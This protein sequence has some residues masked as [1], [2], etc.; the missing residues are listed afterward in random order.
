MVSS[1]CIVT[2]PS[3]FKAEAKAICALMEVCS[4][5]VHIRK[6]ESSLAEVIELLSDIAK[7]GGNIERITLH[8]NREVATQ[9]GLGGLHCRFSEIGTAKGFAGKFSV[10]CHSFLEAREALCAGASY[11]FLSPIF[12]S[13]S[14]RGY[15]A[16]FLESELQN[17]LKEPHNTRVVALGG[18][19]A[20]NIAKVGSMGFCGAALCGALWCVTKDGGAIDVEATLSNFRAIVQRAKVCSLQYITAGNSLDEIVSEVTDFLAGGGR[21]VQLRMKWA[22]NSEMVAVAS[23]IKPLISAVSGVLIINDRA[24]VAKIAKADGLHIGKYDITI[25]EARAILGPNIIIGQTANSYQ[26]VVASSLNGADYIGLG[27]YRFTTTKEKLSPVLGVEGY[28]NIFERLEVIDYHSP[29]VVAIG[30]ITPEDI[31]LL[32]GIGLFGVAIAGAI[33]HSS[34]RKSTTKLFLNLIEKH[35]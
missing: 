11:I 18:I 6:P 14:K 26:D 35:I 33:S 12:D 30:G 25:S 29:P 28:R 24:L 5:R 22:T 2:P 16:A 15:K 19:S 4:C 1:F 27:P 13:I 21:W 7:M 34:D 9:F 17:F 32:S 8:H 20:G 10:S 23:V 31:E 3:V